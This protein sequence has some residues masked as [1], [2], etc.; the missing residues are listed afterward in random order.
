MEPGPGLGGTEPLPP[1]RKGPLG[2]DVMEP[3]PVP[4]GTGPLPPARKRR[5]GSDV[6]EPDPR[7]GRT[8]PLPG[9]RAGG[10]DPLPGPGKVPPA[11]MGT[12]PFPPASARPGVVDSPGAPASVKPGVVDSPVAPASVKPD[13]A[14]QSGAP[15]SQPP[16]SEFPMSVAP[17]KKKTVGVGFEQLT[18]KGRYDPVPLRPDELLVVGMW[19]DM[20]NWYLKKWSQYQGAASF[21]AASKRLFVSNVERAIRL[22]M[23]PD[24][25]AAVL[26]ERR[27]V[28]IIDAHG[29]AFD[30]LTEATAARN[31]LRNTI[32]KIKERLA[33]LYWKPDGPKPGEIAAL[34][35]KLKDLSDLLDFYGKYK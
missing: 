30:H 33:D 35:E 22:R 19:T 17:A 21:P 34:H 5:L 8:V 2:T 13:A 29:K 23:T 15:A 28:K 27:G 4:G 32:A 18:D 24:D 25:L 6:T 12:E 16:N 31:S 7:A 1:G 14:A 11:A 20:R 26:K 3:G 9:P 10:T